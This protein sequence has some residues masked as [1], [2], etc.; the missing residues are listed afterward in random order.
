[1]L[2][3]F[4]GLACLASSALSL[5]LGRVMSYRLDAMLTKHWFILVTT[6]SSSVK[7]AFRDL[8]LDFSFGLS[9]F[10]CDFGLFGVRFLKEFIYVFI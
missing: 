1:M 7:S 8:K 2:G 10:S 5:S 9:C 3:Q 4:S 6:S